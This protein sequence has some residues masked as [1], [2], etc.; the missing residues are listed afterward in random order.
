MSPAGRA[1]SSPRGEPKPAFSAFE[2]P[3]AASVDGTKATVWGQLRAPAAATG[4]ALL[5]R[6]VGSSW[7]VLAK[8]TPS[9]DGVVSWRG[10]LARGSIIRVVA[11]DLFSVPFVVA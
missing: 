6:Q 5:E 7:R 2:L 9:S 8:L 1:G 11:G 10:T 3:L 4:T